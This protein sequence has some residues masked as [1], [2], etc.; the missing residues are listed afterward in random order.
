[1]NERIIE[2]H[3]IAPKEFWG[4]QDAHLETIKRY[5]PKLKIVARGTT[6]KA[7]GEKEELDEFEDGFDRAD[8]HEMIDALA[9][10]I[11]I[12]AGEM[13][14]LGFNPELCLKQTVKEITCRE[15]DPEQAIAWAAGKKEL[16]E[17][18]LKDPKQDP[19]TIYTAD[20]STCRL[21]TS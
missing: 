17:K 21:H 15:Q 18:W 8:T 13:V 19:S 2:L 11:V 6:L 16:G 7:F 12:A 14:K 10:I 5:Y 20:Y 3:D 9:D 1:M 4:A